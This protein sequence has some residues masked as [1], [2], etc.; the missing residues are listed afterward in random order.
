MHHECLIPIGLAFEKFQEGRIKFK[1]TYKYD[2]GTNDFNTK[3]MRI[4]S[5]TVSCVQ[6]LS[7]IEKFAYC[8]T[9]YCTEFAR[10]VRSPASIMTLLRTSNCPITNLCMQCLKWISDLEETSKLYY[11]TLISAINFSFIHWLSVPLCGGQFK[12]S[13]WVEGE[14]IVYATIKRFISP[15]MYF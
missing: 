14:F 2:I 8:R 6:R 11:T 12:K 15:D 9:E 7:V 10:K 1:P 4:P 5:Y 13:V 3:K